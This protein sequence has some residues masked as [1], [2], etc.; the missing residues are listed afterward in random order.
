MAWDPWLG[1]LWAP[2]C[3]FPFRLHGAKSAQFRS[4]M[5]AFQ[6][7]QHSLIS[8]THVRKPP[9]FDPSLKVYESPVAFW[10]V[11]AGAPRFNRSKNK[12]SCYMNKGNKVCIRNQQIVL[13]QL[14]L[15]GNLWSTVVFTK[16]LPLAGSL[17]SPSIQCHK[18][19]HKPGTCDGPHGSVLSFGKQ[20]HTSKLVGGWFGIITAEGWTQKNKH[21]SASRP[22]YFG[23]SPQFW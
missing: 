6:S 22:I 15:R 11:V 21:T 14:G 12:S 9:T 18:K 20:L 7:I 19:E 17:G 10:R 23:T 2:T 16:C 3:P 8:S 1:C 13:A 4:R 5:K